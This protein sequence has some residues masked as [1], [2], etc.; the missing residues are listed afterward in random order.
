MVSTFGS[1]LRNTSIL[2]MNKIIEVRKNH[3]EFMIE[4]KSS[5]DSAMRFY[6][7]NCGNVYPRYQKRTTNLIPLFEQHLIVLTQRSAEYNACDTL[8]TVN[9]LLPLGTLPPNIEH[10]DPKW[11]QLRL[12][13]RL[14]KVAHTTGV[15]H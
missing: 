6:G 3:R 7:G 1:L 12:I 14:T 4:S 8:E 5:R 15:V 13:V 11:G 9:P 10:V 2:F